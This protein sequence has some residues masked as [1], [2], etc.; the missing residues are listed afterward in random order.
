MDEAGL[1]EWLR[2]PFSSIDLKVSPEMYYY[3][4]SFEALFAEALL[5]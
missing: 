1:V 5:E 3:S 4:G 2:W